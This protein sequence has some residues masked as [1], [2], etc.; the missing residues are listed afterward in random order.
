M[1]ASA[2]S[3]SSRT[4]C[5]SGKGGAFAPPSFLLRQLLETD[6]A[7]LLPPGRHQAS[8]ILHSLA[9]ISRSEEHTSELQSRQYLVCRLLLEKKNTQQYVEGDIAHAASLS[10]GREPDDHFWAGIM[11]ACRLRLSR[12][13]RLP[14]TSNALLRPRPK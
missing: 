7:G 5:C 8:L 12:F 13:D 4:W 10:H 14:C 3:S 9:S 11:E 6:E 2:S 1:P